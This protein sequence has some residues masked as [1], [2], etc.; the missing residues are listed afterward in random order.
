MADDANCMQLLHIAR[1][2]HKYQFKS[3]KTWASA[4]LSRYYTRIN[5]FEGL[6][7]V[8]NDSDDAN[9]P[10]LTQITELAGLCEIPELLEAAVDKWRRLVSEGK[11]VA[12][13]I[14]LAERLNMRPLLG[15]AYD[16]P[17]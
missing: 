12:L 6:S 5:A 3:I 1:I 8:T 11:D 13:A 10:S 7:T 9:T 17:R 16:A 2:A 14:G 15:L 4:A